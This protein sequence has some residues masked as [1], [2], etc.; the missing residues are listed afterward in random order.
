MQYPVPAIK[1][2]IYQQP[3]L[4]SKA[5]CCKGNLLREGMDT[6]LIHMFKKSKR[7]NTR[8]SWLPQK[9]GIFQTIQLTLCRVA[10]SKSSIILFVWLFSN[11]QVL[12]VATVL[13]LI[14]RMLPISQLPIPF[15][16]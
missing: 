14:F 9:A 12:A 7:K 3:E 4:R 13:Y 16:I 8:I 15:K 2:I 10:S 5:E 1:P 6:N 11:I